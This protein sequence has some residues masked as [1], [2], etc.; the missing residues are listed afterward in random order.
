MII[1]CTTMSAS[2]TT[3]PFTMVFDAEQGSLPVTGAVAMAGPITGALNVVATIGTPNTTGA[4]IYV[5]NP[6]GTTYT[7]KLV[8]VGSNQCTTAATAALT[9]TSGNATL[10]GSNYN[11]IQI[12]ANDY[13]LIGY[14]VYRTA[15]GGTPSTIGYIGWDP[16]TTS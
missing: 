15:S 10:S 9:T 1:G 12:P 5:P 7:Y 16:I 3:Y 14:K 11:L 4:T 8:G 6:G 2:A 13:G